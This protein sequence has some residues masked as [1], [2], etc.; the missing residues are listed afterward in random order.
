LAELLDENLL[1]NYCP[2]LLVTTDALT[3]KSNVMRGL[4]RS[5]GTKP[6]RLPIV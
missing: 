6:R 4:R 3:T 5:G 1:V 2:S